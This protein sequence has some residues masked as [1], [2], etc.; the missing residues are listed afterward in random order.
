MEAFG[1]VNI[2][3]TLLDRR[4]GKLIVFVAEQVVRDESFKEIADDERP[5]DGKAVGTVDTGVYE[6][7]LHGLCG[8]SE[9]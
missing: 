7:C 8:T 9:E 1:E 6:A 3:L 2:G 5:A 4:R